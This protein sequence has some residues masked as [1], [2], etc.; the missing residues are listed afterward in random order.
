[1]R[2]LVCATLLLSLSC[3]GGDDGSSDAG[4]LDAGAVDAGPFDASFDAGTDAGP[5]LVCPAA[6][7]AEGDPCTGEGLLRCYYEL[8]PEGLYRAECGPLGYELLMDPCSEY[9]CEGT[10]CQGD[11]LCLIHQG[12]ELGVDCADNPCGA[13]A[14]DEACACTLCA[15]GTTCT[16]TGTTVTCQEVCDPG[17]CA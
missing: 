8:C 7:P 14:I 3:G 10:T 1:M 17:P 11:E 2:R 13:G 15:S 9:D 5:L 12:G 4:P 16:L 6:L